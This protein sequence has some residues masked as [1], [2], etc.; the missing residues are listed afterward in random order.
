VKIYPAL[1]VTTDS[2]DVV[3]ALVDD[4][5]P[6]AVDTERPQTARIFF[7]SADARDAALRALTPR[8]A[9]L[10]VDVPD[11]DWARRSQ[12]N[13]TPVTVGQITVFPTPDSTARD[14]GSPA[15][16]VI[17]SMGFGT[18]HHATTRLCLAALQEVPLANR[19]VLDVGT[20]SGVLA[21]AA[22]RLGAARALGIDSDPD[23]VESARENLELNPA[24]TDVDFELADLAA[25][26]LPHADVVTANLTGALL[27]RS[28]A[29]LLSAVR[30]GGFLILSG[31]LEGERDAVASAF[32]GDVVWERNEEEWLALVFRAGT[33]G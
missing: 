17:P 29:R 24:L 6:T 1:D 18:G 14:R 7:P 21:L 32:G 33:G 2:S 25:A 4:F 23:A 11:E 13:L 8:F 9:V 16:V 27:M 22:R 15:I 28:A 5:G 10:P 30:P 26:A 3:L 31:I 20:G 12:E 19:A